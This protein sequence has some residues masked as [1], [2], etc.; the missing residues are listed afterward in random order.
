VARHAGVAF[1]N[2]EDVLDDLFGIGLREGIED[3]VDELA[4]AQVGNRGGALGTTDDLAMGALGREGPLPSIVAFSA[5]KS[6][7][8][9]QKR[10]SIP[11]R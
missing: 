3:L 4:H 5:P 1:D 6:L 9:A 11:P 2:D 7:P 10:K 8:C